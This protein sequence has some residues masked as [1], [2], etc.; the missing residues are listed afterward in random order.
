MKRRSL[1]LVALSIFSIV[2]VL[3]G[4]LAW[5]KISPLFIRTADPRVLIPV[6]NYQPSFGDTSPTPSATSTLRSKMPTWTP[7]SS[8]T[9]I[10]TLIYRTP[11]RIRTYIFEAATATR[12]STVH[13]SSTPT[14]T[15]TY[16][17][18]FTSTRTQTTTFTP[19]L[20]STLTMTATWTP[21]DKATLTDSPVPTINTPVPP[22]DTDTPVPPDTDTPYPA[23]TDTPVTP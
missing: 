3:A 19:T 13:P 2:L 8:P 14:P 1:N 22:P 16:T 21:T 7:F 15:F 6:T 23:D 11:T 4:M 18:T 12:T 5:P 17:A 20:T 10:N 9:G